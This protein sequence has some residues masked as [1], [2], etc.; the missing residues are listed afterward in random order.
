MGKFGS[1]SAGLRA[2]RV[3]ELAEEAKSLSPSGWGAV[4]VD[5]D[6]EVY[7]PAAATAHDPPAHA[8][9]WDALARKDRAPPSVTFRDVTQHWYAGR[10]GG[11]DAAIDNSQRAMRRDGVPFPV[12]H[13][14]RQY[15]EWSPRD[16]DAP[17]AVVVRDLPAGA[18]GRFTPRGIDIAPLTAAADGDHSLRNA[19]LEHEATHGLTFTPLVRKG[20]ER[21]WSANYAHLPFH[22]S[23]FPEGISALL[24]PDKEYVLRRSE[25]DPRLAEIRRRYAAFANKDV[26][27][28][29][30]A[31]AAWEWWR[32]NQH[33]FNLGGDQPL[34]T[35]YP[36]AFALYDDMPAA[37][38]S[39]L[40]KRMM[41][42][43]AMAA[44]IAA[45]GLL[46]GLRDS[47]EQSR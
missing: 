7:P 12:D 35:L 20:K 33:R 16:A 24:S 1:A 4:A 5:S 6:V 3:A 9:V 15:G 37:A 45:G 36:S 11:I 32:Q 30:D 47:R 22:D 41:Q 13:E 23:E 39:I 31:A 14:S 43:P 26:N 38:K 2:A 27:T 29:E 19:I 46:E 28:V 40:H 8:Q 44:P 42:V 34:A 21:E 25:V 17:M 18:A 10:P